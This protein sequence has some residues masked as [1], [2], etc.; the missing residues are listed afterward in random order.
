MFRCVVEMFGLPAEITE[1]RE[2]EVE[3][4][5]GA[6]LRDVVAAIRRKIPAL[7]GTAIRIGEDQLVENYKFNVNG[8]F[9]YDDMGLKIKSGDRIALLV[10]ITGG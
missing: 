9:Y 6:T 1:L 3:L 2:V 4:E 10:P 5:N 8:H 7:E